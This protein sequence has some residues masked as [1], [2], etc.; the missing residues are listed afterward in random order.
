LT[1]L[2]RAAASA[3]SRIRASRL[4]PSDLIFVAG[5]VALWHGLELVAEP[6][7]YIVV[8]LAAVIFGSGLF[9]SRT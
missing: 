1:R 3:R 6:L 2:R 4:G 7:P 5:V 9:A 8:G